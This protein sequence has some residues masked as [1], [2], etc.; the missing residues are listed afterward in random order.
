MVKY[1]YCTH[2]CTHNSI[3]Y[4]KLSM[5]DAYLGYNN[6]CVTRASITEQNKY[7]VYIIRLVLLCRQK[8]KQRKCHCMITDTTMQYTKYISRRWNFLESEMLI[9]NS[10]LACSRQLVIC[11]S[12]IGSDTATIHGATESKWSLLLLTAAA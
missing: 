4:Y 12:T 3:M 7:T 1:M 10:K 9:I 11:Q 5:H 8:S 6:S 2:P